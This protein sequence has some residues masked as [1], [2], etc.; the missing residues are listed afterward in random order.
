MWTEVT[1]SLVHLRGYIQWR[2]T[3]ENAT[4]AVQHDRQTCLLE[5]IGKGGTNAGSRPFRAKTALTFAILEHSVAIVP[6]RLVWNLIAIPKVRF[7]TSRSRA[8]GVN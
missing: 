1:P 5:A 2:T 6:T 7:A 3:T 8:F 4:S